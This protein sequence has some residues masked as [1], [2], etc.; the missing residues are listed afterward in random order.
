MSF[1]LPELPYPQDELEPH[2][3]AKT[4]SFHYGKHHKTYVDKLNLLIKGSEH[5]NK[6][7]EDIIM[8]TSGPIFNN[9]AQVWNHSFYWQCLRAAQDNN[10]PT[11]KIAELLTKTFGSIQKFI[12]LFTDKAINN[13]GSSWTWLVL[14]KNNDLEIINTSNAGNP[15]TDGMKP[16]LTCDL[17]EHAYYLDY[18]NLRPK[19]IEAFWKLVNWDFVETNL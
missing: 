6:S 2:I 3:S 17:W 10:Q 1:N 7:L 11:T 18:Q 14:N 19:Y 9:A 13:F 12:E 8:S 15:M 5:E 4:L 16:L